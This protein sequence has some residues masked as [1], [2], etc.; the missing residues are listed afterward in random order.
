MK[1]LSIMLCLIAVLAFTLVG[2][3]GSGTT[4]TGYYGGGDGGGD[5][6]PTVTSCTANLTP[7]QT[8]T[9]TGSGF[10]SSRDSNQSTV[11]FVPTND[12]GSIVAGQTYLSWTDTQIV[13]VTPG[14][15]TGVKYV[16]V[17]N[18]VTSSGSV[19]S[20]S[21]ATSSNSTTGT[22]PVN[23]PTITGQSPNPAIAGQSVTLTGTNFPTSGGWLTVNNAVVST[24]FTAITATFT[25]PSTLTANA[26]VALGGGTG[27]LV[28]GTLAIS[29]PTSPTITGVSPSSVA[30][31]GTLTLTGT[32]FGTTAGSV[33]V[34]TVA[35]TGLTWSA[36]Q[37]TGTL[38]A[39]SNSLIAGQTYTVTLTTSTNLTATSSV[40]IA[41]PT[42]DPVITGITPASA[43]QGSATAITIAGTKFGTTAGS[44]SLSIGTT[45]PIS[46]PVTTWSDTSVTTTVPGTVPVGNYTLNLTTSGSKIAGYA[47]SVTALTNP[48]V[49]S[50]TA[51]LTT[52]QTCTIGGTNFGSSKDGGSSTVTFTPTAGGTAITVANYLTWSDTAITLVTPTLVTGTQYVVVV[53]RVTSSGTLS[54]SSTPSS[55]NTTTGTAPTTPPAITSQ[56]P[57]PA[58]AG[59]AV[60]LTGTSFPT[61]GGWLTVNGT[62][63]SSV[64]WTAT[65]AAFTVPAGITANAS[66]IIGGGAGGA[67]AAYTLVV[68]TGGTVV[69]S[70]ISPST[71]VSGAATPVTITGT[72]FGTPQGTSY[73]TFGTTQVTAVTTWSAT[74]IVV[75]TPTTLAAG[76]TTITVT[77]GT[78]TSNAYPLAVA[79]VGTP[80]ISS[81]TPTSVARGG[82][83]TIA[84]VNFGATQG[85]G[86]VTFGTIVQGAVTTWADG[87][88]TC[89]VPNT[90]PLGTAIPIYVTPS[91]GTASAGYNIEITDVPV[92]TGTWHTPAQTVSS[93]NGVPGGAGQAFQ[94]FW[95]F[96]NGNG[97]ILYKDSVTAARNSIVAQYY[98]ASTGTWSTTET[99]IADPA[100]ANNVS[101][102]SS[103]MDTN[104]NVMV[105]W[106]QPNPTATA[107]RIYYQY[108]N[109]TTGAWSGSVTTSFVD[110]AN[111][112]VAAGGG[113]PAVA[114]DSQGNAVCV[115]KITSAATPNGILANKYTGSA[116]LNTPAQINVD[117]AID[118]VGTKCTNTAS[119]TIG[120]RP[121]TQIGYAGWVETAT[122]GGALS[123]QT[124][125]YVRRVDTSKANASWN[126][127]NTSD[128][129]WAASASRVDF[130]GAA[131]D[132]VTNTQI[133][134]TTNAGMLLFEKNDGVTNN[135]YISQYNSTADQFTA[136]S[137]T[138]SRI[139]NATITAGS[140]SS[141]VLSNGNE[142]VV[143]GGG[144]AILASTFNGTTW[145]APEAIQALNAGAV[146]GNPYVQADGAGNAFCTFLQDNATTAARDRLY[147]SRY[148]S[149]IWSR[150]ADSDTIDG[151]TTAAVCP[152]PAIV[153]FN[154]S[155][156]AFCLF[157]QTVGGVEKLFQNRWY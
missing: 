110:T 23:P 82:N 34:G 31:G 18:K 151:D 139:N 5:T 115:W 131:A 96:P 24:T 56:A 78:A 35:L 143:W 99:D 121:G 95:V 105:V 148:S 53:N 98:I 69:I 89:V 140:P 25:V 3:G 128:S 144:T 30:L 48:A 61:T 41:D 32:A 66:V 136:I 85:T 45:T 39:A 126:T 79:A 125:A 77:V 122:V 120:F 1:K 67:S 46:L 102:I 156:Q 20:S 76:N 141:T 54:S 97:M 28:T 114:F 87:S 38:P 108:Y 43:I 137:G 14:I 11:S 33:K 12:G 9:I 59:A 2:C 70:G 75:N 147:A 81:I 4:D 44:L 15:A 111:S 68:T 37:V 101:N 26:T 146:G 47:F 135:V 132:N 58:T 7:G 27:G 100:N 88:I 149:G 80:V 55:A 119:P 29:S 36:T 10:G 117:N 50:V 86:Y 71:V 57:N 72:G 112:P 94:N 22:A 153:A 103:A 123:N 138:A 8:C 73:V 104:G 109:Y 83:V 118:A 107:F 62:I 130:Q 133:E 150:P 16:A 127:Y 134:F 17:V 21:T 74:S 152:I 52:G 19:S 64:T 6:T 84:G 63:V 13:L 116:W 145:T 65:T 154:S 51:N 157:T 92:P 49:T 142:I 155:N 113:R 91:G 106:E 129:S 42:T 124:A 40:R 60:T 93:A 90:A